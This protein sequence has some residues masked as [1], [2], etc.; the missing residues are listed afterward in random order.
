MHRRWRRPRWN[1]G[2]GGRSGRTEVVEVEAA[3]VGA[4]EAEA[5]EAE[6]C[7]GGIVMH[8]KSTEVDGADGAG[9][10]Y[11]VSE[12]V[13]WSELVRACQDRLVLVWGYSCCM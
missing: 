4:A 9:S 2:G 5:V 1:I 13:K 11:K 6:G 3:K 7:I 12:A 8:W 10:E